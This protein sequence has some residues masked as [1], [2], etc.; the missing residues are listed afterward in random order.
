MDAAYAF[1]DAPVTHIGVR[2]LGDKESTPIDLSHHL[3]DMSNAR[4]ASPLKALMKYMAQPGMIS[5]SG[6]LPHESYFPF[7]E[8]SAQTAVPDTF[9]LTPEEKSSFSWLWNLFGAPTRKTKEVT[10]PKRAA[11][12]DMEAVQLATALQ[13][14]QATGLPLLQK[15]INEFVQ[16]VYRPINPLTTTLVHVGN[17]DGW[18]KAVLTLC[19]HGEGILVEEYTYPSAIASAWPIGVRPVPV[20][21]DSEGMLANDLDHVLSGWDVEAR[22]GMKKPH[23]MYTVP[24]GQNPCG[25]TMSE[26]RKKEIYAVCVKHDVIIVED[27]PYYFLQCGTYVPKAQRTTA[28]VAKDGKDAE[29]AFIQSLAPSYLRVDYQGR[30][31]RLDTFSKTIAPGSRLGFFTCNPMFAERLLRAGETSTQAP[32]GFGQALITSLLNGWGMSG[33]IRWLRGIRAQYTMRRDMCMDALYNHFDLREDLRASSIRAWDGAPVLVAHKKGAVAQEKYDSTTS[34]FSIVPPVA[35]MFLWIQVHVY[36]H[37]AYDDLVRSGM[38]ESL[39]SATLTFR[40]WKK[41]VDNKVLWSPGWFFATDG[42]Q[43]D[44]GEMGFNPAVKAKGMEGCFRVAYSSASPEEMNK[45]MDV[46]AK[47]VVKFFE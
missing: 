21:M 43:P 47:Q 30:V 7:E 6:G 20:K 17:T 24:V 44:I 13:Y 32:C 37:P 5:M 19:N 46:F 40:L 3:S 34:L 12:G 9:S 2:S 14:G 18:A 29:E 22:G 39:A 36:N 15:F 27:D 38:S 1:P 31:I 33:W 45:A 35:G 28:K 23:V 8:I 41:L 42:V 16:R 4:I 10:I 11:G 25:T 26:K